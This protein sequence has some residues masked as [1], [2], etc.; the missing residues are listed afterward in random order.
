MNLVGQT[1]VVAP[2][3]TN[4]II[5]I[6]ALSVWIAGWRYQHQFLASLVL[7][8]AIGTVRIVA[9]FVCAYAL[10]TLVEV[11]IE[12]AGTWPRGL[13]SLTAAIASELVLYNYP[14]SSKPG[15]LQ[16]SVWINQ[17]L[18]PWMRVAMIGF[19]CVLLLEPIISHEEE[20]EED[21]YVAVLLDSSDSMTLQS[22]SATDSGLTREMVARQLLTGDGIGSQGILDRLAKDYRLKLYRLGANA[23]PTEIERISMPTSIELTPTNARPS[24]SWSQSTDYSA[25]LRQ[26][27]NDLSVDELSGIILLSDG[28]DHSSNDLQQSVRPFIQGQVPINSVVIGSQSPVRDAEVV[29]VQVPSQVFEGDSVAVRAVVKIDEFTGQNATVRLLKDGEL[30]EER[31]LSV[32]SKRHR[33]SVLFRHQP[34]EVGIHEYQVELEPIPGE[35][36]SENNQL[37]QF[38]A[39]SKDRIHLL[40]IDD[41]PRWEFRYLR[42]LFNGRDLTVYLQALLMHPDKLAGVPDPPVMRA[43]ALRAFDDC[44][45]TALPNSREEWLKFDVIV[46]GDVSRELLG[47]EGMQ[48]IDEFVTRRG[49]TLLVI[50]GQHYMPHTFAKTRFADLLPVRLDVPSALNSGPETQPYFLTP[51]ANAQSHVIMQ[52]VGA[53]MGTLASRFPELSWR[54]P[55]C[56]AKS[57]ATVLAYASNERPKDAETTEG[58]KLLEQERKNALMLW[59]RVGAGKVLQMTF[60][61]SWRLRYGVGDKF[62][63]QYWGQM[64]RWAVSDRLSAGTEFVR[65]GTDRAMVRA[66]DTIMVRARLIDDK[67]NPITQEEVQA[68]VTF[69]DEVVRKISLTVR[70]DSGGLLVGEIQGLEKAGKYKIE[71]AGTAVE[72]LLKLEGKAD[73][74]VATNVTVQTSNEGAEKADLVADIAIPTQLASRSGGTVVTPE[75]INP[76]FDKLGEPST[77]HRDRWTVS[78]WNLWPVMASFLAGLCVEWIVRKKQ[79]LI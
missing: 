43:S 32:S 54:H 40:I 35:E 67:Y 1:T 42:N 23:R 77:Y 66:N 69:N 46:L 37:S 58:G 17:I 15:P 16:R 56:E 24:S 2:S 48:A 39:V 33:E 68:L 53:G 29:S 11:L 4:V 7:T 27:A 49:G 13:L 74:K 30:V 76:L 8:I 3:F 51:S 12:T 14:S 65:L 63:H 41:H 79:G 75:N 62:H 47:E 57:G 55:A 25:A 72:R 9:A 52:E 45:A 31:K 60:D 28:C 61:Q 70:A 50:S 26:V 5:V 18:L 22:R 19:L 10:F 38:V 20:R 6:A 34:D 73:T 78:L 44:E 21:R 59:H 64:I 71:L 36:T